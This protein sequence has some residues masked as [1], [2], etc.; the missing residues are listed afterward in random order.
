MCT[1]MHA[2][3]CTST[4]VHHSS[5]GPSS[6]THVKA[7]CC[8]FPL[9]QCIECAHLLL[10]HIRKCCNHLRDISTSSPRHCPQYFTS[11]YALGPTLPFLLPRSKLLVVPRGF[12]LSKHHGLKIRPLLPRTSFIP[13]FSASV[14]AFSL[15]QN[16]SLTCPAD[17]PSLPPPFP[18]SVLC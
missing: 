4:G 7:S 3:M 11:N 18:L 16:L 6:G 5:S 17:P 2:H 1:C 12:T 8:H 14:S 15:G 9:P 13:F 10:S